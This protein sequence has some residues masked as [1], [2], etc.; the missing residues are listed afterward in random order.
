MLIDYYKK[1]HSQVRL[2][3]GA[4]YRL[5][6]T[7]NAG[8]EDHVGT[9]LGQR[10]A[11]RGDRFQGPGDFGYAEDYRQLL[12][13][14]PGGIAGFLPGSPLPGDRGGGADLHLRHAFFG[15][16]YRAQERIPLHGGAFSAGCDN[17]V[18]GV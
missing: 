3:A 10:G 2:P 1:L 17:T 4:G 15:A 5:H 16:V 13:R 14:G 11:V 7:V 6:S 12:G 8:R 18:C 9:A